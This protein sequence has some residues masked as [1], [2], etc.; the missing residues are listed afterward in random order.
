[1]ACMNPLSNNAFMRD[2][3]SDIFP[4]KPA[5]RTTVLLSNV[6]TKATPFLRQIIMEEGEPC[7]PVPLPLPGGS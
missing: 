5:E 3:S 2:E 4:I 7:E 1:M 6:N